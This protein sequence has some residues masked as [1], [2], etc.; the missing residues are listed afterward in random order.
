MNNGTPKILMVDDDP[1]MRLLASEMLEQDGFTVL[2]ADSG[3]EALRQFAATGADLI[4]LD[5]IMPGWD[6]FATCQQLRQTPAGSQTPIVMMTGLGDEASIQRAYDAGATDFIVKPIIRPILIQ[7]VRYVLRASAALREVAARADFQKALI[8]TTPV[9]IRV[10]DAHGRSL[11]CNPAFETLF[12]GQEVPEPTDP[13]SPDWTDSQVYEAE[14]LNSHQEQRSVIIHRAMFTP[15]GSGE[16]GIISAILD[17]TER[18]QSE[19]QLRLAE[20]VFQTAADAIMVTDAT[21]V[22]QSINPAFTAITGYALEEAIGQTLRLLRSERHDTLFYTGLWRSLAAN[23]RWSG[24]IWQRHKNGKTYPAWE[25]IEAVRDLDGHIVQYV[26]F[27]SDITQRKLAEQEIF[28]RANYDP[29]TGLPNRSLL[30]ERIEQALKRA[31]RQRQ[32]VGLMFLDIDRFKQVND[33]LGHTWGDA[34]LGQIAERLKN[35]VRAT[36]TVARYSGD[37]F[38]LVLADMIQDQDAHVLAEKVIK[39]ISEQFDLNDNAV[40]IG[41]SIGIVMYPDHG[42]DAATLLRHADLA[43]YQAKNAGR[44]TYRKYESAMTDRVLLQ[45]SLETDLRLALERNEF[46]VYY[47]PIHE[48]VGGNLVGAEALVR[49][50]HPRRGLVPPN[51][52]IPLAEETGLIREVGAWVLEWVCRTLRQWQH[53]GLRIPVSVNLSSVQILRGL[54]V[55]AV[56]DLL[57]RYDLRPEQLA[58]E[59]TE[60]VL[61]SDTLQAQRWLEA[62]REMGIRVDMD[63]FGTGYSSLA[64]LKRFPIDRI[65]ID[66]SFVRDIVVNAND[67]SL[68]EAVLAMASSLHLQVVAEGVE[69]AE[70]LA[71]LRR[72]GCEYAQGFYFSR[73]VPEQ[74]FVKFAEGLGALRA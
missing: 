2:E 61:I 50:Q 74:E 4:L 26:A 7:R 54:T 55:G 20:T 51:D 12:G 72:L 11:I 37:E 31:H 32:R 68:V 10:E 58:F 15:P 22:I 52:F 8:D 59:I 67:R 23:G 28:F 62:V 40:H 13:T 60:S 65:K 39:R 64:Y 43:M 18:K 46:L 30:H 29:L 56:R 47:Q 25:S 14:M 33:T 41:V 9:P 63:D 45:V 35:C 73:P 34:L 48:V 66:R 36:D 44:N 70:Q 5:V 57:E 19:E 27:F 6:G 69:D 1:M 3:E 21:G 49:W 38:V 53:I 17:I 42:L 71:L 16:P 24:E